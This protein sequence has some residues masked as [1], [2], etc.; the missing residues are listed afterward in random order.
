ML[1]PLRENFFT[2]GVEVEITPELHAFLL[3]SGHGHPI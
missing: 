1:G 2:K 3:A